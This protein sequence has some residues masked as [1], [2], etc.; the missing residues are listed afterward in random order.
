M[1]ELAFVEREMRRAAV[2]DPAIDHAA[3]LAHRRG[4]AEFCEVRYGFAAR[5]S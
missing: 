2:G 5:D 3:A 4:V 1:R